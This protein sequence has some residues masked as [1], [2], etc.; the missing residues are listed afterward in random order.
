MRHGKWKLL[1]EYDGA[2]VELYDM[3]SDR[4]ETGSVAVKHPEVVARLVKSLLAWHESMP[5]DKGADFVK[6]PRPRK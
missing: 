5:A 3:E 2:E 1:C 6:K 4:G